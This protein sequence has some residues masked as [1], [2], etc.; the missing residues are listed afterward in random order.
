VKPAANSDHR[1]ANRRFEIVG[2]M[3][4]TLASTQTMQVMNVGVSG[5][6]LESACAL[7]Q[8]AEFQV[9]LILEGHVSEA[10][11]KVKRVVPMRTAPGGPPRYQIGVE[12]LSITPEAED[13]INRLILD[14]M[15]AD[16]GAE[17]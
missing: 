3:T 8:Y 12:F 16:L 15:A 5:A 9:Q 2:K 13:E 14:R 11:V 6:L 7:P 4:G 1:R 17:A 10:M